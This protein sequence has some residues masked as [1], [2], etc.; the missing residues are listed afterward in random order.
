MNAQ[1]GFKTLL[2]L[3]QKVNRLTLTSRLHVQNHSHPKRKILPFIFRDD[4]TSTDSLGKISQLTSLLSEQEENL[5]MTASILANQIKT[6]IEISDPTK[7]A[8]MGRD[9]N[10]TTI[11][12]EP[13]ANIKPKVEP[14]PGVII[15]KKAHRK[16]KIK[17]RKMKVH[18]RKKRWRKYWAIWR[19]KYAFNEKRREIEFRHRLIAKVHEAQKFDPEKFVDDYLEDMKYELVAKTWKGKR[20]PKFLIKELHEKELKMEERIKL[21]QT[22]MLTG[23]TLVKENETVE[24][25]IKRNN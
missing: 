7:R 2:N 21:N 1:R 5:L 13:G 22:N 3:S 15:E 18:R 6:K 9:C 19:K 4:T 23:E 16:L 17:K 11:L 25:F 14:N 20:L 8:P 24:D 12:P 10:D